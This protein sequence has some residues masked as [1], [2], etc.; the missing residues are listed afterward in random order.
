MQT[1]HF[2]RKEKDFNEKVFTNSGILTTLAIAKTE[3]ISYHCN[4]DMKLNIRI[5]FFLLLSLAIVSPAFSQKKENYHENQNPFGKKKKERKNQSKALSK[6]GGGGLFKKKHSAGNADAFANN[7]IRG[8]RGFL[9]KIFGGGS[10]SSKNASL[11]K[12]K[13]GKSQRKE[14]SALFKRSRSSN[15]KK[16]SGTQQK[17]RK[18]RNKTRERG[19]SVF[20]SKKH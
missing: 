7:S 14:D 2:R 8:G 19:N 17:E 1:S 4:P 20:H 9:S 18:H 6:R 12:T 11:R 10:A 15:K 5:L 13:S 16:Y 3:R